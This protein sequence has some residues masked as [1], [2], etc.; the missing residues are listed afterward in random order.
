MDIETTDKIGKRLRTIQG[1]LTSKSI[2]PKRA[3]NEHDALDLNLDHTFYK[4]FDHE[5]DDSW[6][7]VS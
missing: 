3:K 1:A 2:T 7:H 4:G 6:S 5:D